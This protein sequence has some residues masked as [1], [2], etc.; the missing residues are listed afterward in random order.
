VA[1]YRHLAQRIGNGYN[2]AKLQH[3]FR[4]FVDASARLTIGKEE[5]VVKP[6]RR[7][8]SPLLLAVGFANIAVPIP[9]LGR[10]RQRFDFGERPLWWC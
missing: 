10:K 5:T 1:Q 7:A 3:V 2:A 9:W 4:D 8:H 6:Q